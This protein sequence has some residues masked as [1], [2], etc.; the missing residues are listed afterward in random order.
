MSSDQSPNTQ[1][2]AKSAE[3]EESPNSS[4]AVESNTQSEDIAMSTSDVDEEA[5]DENSDGKKIGDNSTQ[6]ATKMEPKHQYIL[7]QALFLKTSDRI[8][9]DIRVDPYFLLDKLSG[10]LSSPSMDYAGKL[11]DYIQ[12][13]L[14]RPKYRLVSLK[15]SVDYVNLDSSRELGDGYKLKVFEGLVV[16]SLSSGIP[17]DPMFHFIIKIKGP[18]N[19]RHL[20]HMFYGFSDEQLAP[21]DRKDL[22]LNKSAIKEQLNN[23]ENENDKRLADIILKSLP[24]IVDSANFVSLRTKTVMRVEISEPVI[25][26]KELEAFE[27]D[28]IESRLTLYMS[29]VT[30]RHPDKNM[31]VK[32]PTTLE[33]LK[34]LYRILSGPFDNID[35]TYSKT[36]KTERSPILRFHLDL[37]ILLRIFFF[38]KTND[39]SQVELEPPR[40]H[41]F[42]DFEPVVT[43]Y[44]SRALQEVLYIMSVFSINSSSIYNQQLDI[45]PNLTNLFGALGENDLQNQ[46]KG[47]ANWGLY[48]YN[49]G[50]TALSANNYYPDDLVIELYNRMVALD[51][52]ATPIYLDAL[53]FCATSCGGQKLQIYASTLQSQGMFGFNELRTCFIKLGFEPNTIKSLADITDD[54]LI[55]SYK[56]HLILSKSLIESSSYRDALE[57]IGAYRDSSVIKI[58]LDTEP[59]HDLNEA[60]STLE[61][62]PSVDDDVLIT[63]YQ[64]K[65]EE[66][67][68]YDARY[69]RALMAIAIHRRSMMLMSYIDTNMPNF[70]LGNISFE[71]AL[72]NIG[73]DK[74]ASDSS[75]IRIFQERINME[76]KLDFQRAWTSLKVVGKARNSKLIENYLATGIINLA[77][78]PIDKIPTGLNN[79]GN[80]C[81]LNSLL[82]Y[83]FAIKPIRDLT[84]DFDKILTP[85][86]FGKDPNYKIRRIGGRVVRYKETERSYQFMYQLKNLYYTMIH[87]NSRCVTPTRELAYLAFSP[88]ESEVEFNY[89]SPDNSRDHNDDENADQISDADVVLSELDHDETGSEVSDGKSLEKIVTDGNS[90]ED[91]V[92]MD[93]GNTENQDGNAASQ[94][95]SSEKDN[96]NESDSM[97]TGNDSDNESCTASNREVLRSLAVAQIGYDQIEN[98]FELGRQQDV[99]ECISNVLSQIECALNPDELDESNEQLDSVKKLFYGKTKQTLV[100]YDVQARKA[101]PDNKPRTKI[102][103]FLNL[104]VN[105]G[106]HPK[107]IYDALDT[108]FTEDLLKLEEEEVKRSLTITELPSIL[109]IQIQRVQFD[110]VRLMPVK[111]TEPIPFGEKLYMDR[112]MD[113]DDKNII[114][115]REKVFHWRRELECL[116]KRKVILT[117]VDER[118]LSPKDALQSTKQFLQSSIINQVGVLVDENTLE[119]LDHEQEK[120]D[121]ELTEINS[122]IDA[123]E[124]LISKQFAE[125]KSIGYSIF[126]IFIH[127]GEASYGHYWIY[128]KDSETGMF[129]KYN[130]EIVSEVPMEEVFDFSTSNRATP[131]YL[132]F[133]KDGFKDEIEPVKREII[134]NLV[135]SLD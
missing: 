23:C 14:C 129:R 107:D 125:L 135:D 71:D 95:L 37:E 2:N 30:N 84:L 128:I 20:K 35:S 79:I 105:I 44:F 78:L 116:K 8:F 108:Y 127:R 11:T 120:I 92:K 122:K 45:D 131:Y 115:K 60:Y 61:T 88:I 80:T 32:V 55:S 42:G 112:Y 58:Y 77:L 49:K 85:E 118:G 28:E 86:L 114:D 63:A 50:F 13:S 126:A 130:D 51:T 26:P 43:Q 102:E 24:K 15:S 93:N 53:T 4:S 69:S 47:W 70:S 68:Y 75:L 9:D 81:Y 21:Q 40:F 10:L 31:R 121:K 39:D 97:V 109:Q 91:N 124:S 113:T 98:A 82:Q 16:P 110:R 132:A 34:T 56:D 6:K 3:L 72:N 29:T 90:N 25:P 123:L 96:A 76:T 48:Q 134:E 119:I 104:I 83:Y 17:K 36:L 41:D 22:I 54:Q 59:M 103:R 33:C 19:E 67:N 94:N 62:S 87:A 27:N 74:Y 100:P 18:E 1:N 12:A 65:A 5:V 117:K 66:S 52:L 111:S 7:G 38:K 57:K 101:K 89:P 133:I 46:L 99:T 73:A 64:L 106:D